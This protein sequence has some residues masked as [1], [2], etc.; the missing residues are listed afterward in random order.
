MKIVATTLAAVFLSACSASY[1]R[2]TIPP[3]PVQMDMGTFSQKV[4]FIELMEFVRDNH[5]VAPT[6]DLKKKVDRLMFEAGLSQQCA[7]RSCWLAYGEVKITTDEMF[8]IMEYRD[9]S[10]IKID[11]NEPDRAA[12]VIYG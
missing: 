1:S 2:T 4:H 9:K 6:A 11:I 5:H 8:I 3:A 7:N 12:K 10:V